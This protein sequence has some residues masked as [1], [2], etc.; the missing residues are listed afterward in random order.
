ML[1]LKKY[2]FF[3]ILKYAISKNTQTSA[4]YEVFCMS[5]IQKEYLNNLMEGTLLNF[6][7]I[8]QINSFLVLLKGFF[9]EIAF[10][11]YRLSI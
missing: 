10:I 1:T 7:T 5:I 4:K 3:D 2:M 9:F 8:R 11:E 6:T